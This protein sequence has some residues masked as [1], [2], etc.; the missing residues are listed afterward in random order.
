MRISPHRSGSGA[1][2]HDTPAAGQSLQRPARR[3]PLG[4][5][6]ACG[7]RGAPAACALGVS[8]GVRRPKP[9]RWAL[10]GPRSTGRA[11]VCPTAYVG[12]NCC[13]QQLLTAEWEIACS[14]SPA[15]ADA[16]CCVDFDTLW[17]LGAS[18]SRVPLMPSRIRRHLAVCL[19]LTSSR[20]FW[21]LQ[22]ERAPLVLQ[23]PVLAPYRGRRRAR[24]QG[25]CLS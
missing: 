18:T 11:S 16:V 9:G 5:V 24:Q 20:V 12:V 15:Q 23:S 17:S 22:H 8:V 7:P 25:R 6:R 13:A 2:S 19:A 3:A 10:A 21:R 4:R 14:H 1:C